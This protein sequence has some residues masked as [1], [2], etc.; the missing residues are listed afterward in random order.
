MRRE[1]LRE[2]EL[3]ERLEL[4][5]LERDAL[6]R[7]LRGAQV[8]PTPGA[9]D[10][11]DVRPGSYIGSL[12]LGDHLQVIVRPKLRVAEVM[13][14]ISY[15]LDP[16]AWTDPLLHWRDELVALD[17]HAELYEAI[18]PSFLRHLNRALSR[19]V[20]Q[21]YR[22]EEDALLTVRGR[23]RFDEQIR[24]R[25]GMPVPIEVSYDEFTE[26]IEVNRILR[27]AVN[28]IARTPLRRREHR[29]G[30]R[31]VDSALER[32]SLVEYTR[33]PPAPAFNR[34]NEHY[35]G[36]VELARLILADSSFELRI[37]DVFSHAFLID[38][39]KVFERFALVALREAL[40]VD[41][42]TFP[43][44]AAGRRLHLDESVAPLIDL[45]PDLSWWELDGRPS[46]VGD[47]KYKRAQV[48]EVKH[49]DIYQMLA[50]TIATDLPAGLLVYAAGEA[51]SGTHIVRH[52]GKRLEIRAL[53]ISGSANDV[54]D[55]VGELGNRIRELR[56]EGRRARHRLATAVGR[57][58]SSALGTCSSRLAGAT[59]DAVVQRKARPPRS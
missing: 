55:R 39:N 36:A 3:R 34:L 20:L 38:M 1:Y 24:R 23:I 22:V 28:R 14:L 57:A 48:D 7:L 31:T 52:A 16:S 6:I 43:A 17:E 2:H 27:A 46:F 56:A 35:R 37:G 5:P 47:L 59:A 44:G 15:A 8:T 21:G 41:E 32:V 51:E 30:L 12:S 10:L 11:Y 53:D 40:G 9:T 13:F 19:G 26:D 42:H 45:E 58:P 29:Q 18:V 4:Q 25:L 49:S 33:A 54:L 50:Y